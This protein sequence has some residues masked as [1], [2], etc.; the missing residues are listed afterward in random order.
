MHERAS[1]VEDWFGVLDAGQAFCFEQ[2][3]QRAP[4][5]KLKSTSLAVI[6]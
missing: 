3:S 2:R 1:H 6:A 4:S 5:E